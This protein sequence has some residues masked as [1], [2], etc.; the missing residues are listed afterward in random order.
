MLC[1]G[2]ANWLWPTAVL[3]IAC[4]PGGTATADGHSAGLDAEVVP[5]GTADASPASAETADD[6]VASDVPADA[7]TCNTPNP[8]GCYGLPAA[9][10][11]PKTA[12]GQ[13]QLCVQNS[14]ADGCIPYHCQCNTA[15]GQWKCD[16]SC[17]GGICKPACQ[18][19]APKVN[20]CKDGQ[21]AQPV[22]KDGVY[23]CPAGSYQKALAGCGPYSATPTPG[24]IAC[25]KTSQTY[26]LCPYSYGCCFGV[27][28][29]CWKAESLAKSCYAAVGCDDPQDCGGGQVCCL[30]K[31]DVY[32][33]TA[34]VPPADCQ[35]EGKFR[36]C[37]ADGDCQAGK[38]CCAKAKGGQYGVCLDPPC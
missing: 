19:L 23:S 38:V 35:A 28:T 10:A 14:S 34:C 30:G 37:K 18:V 16:S 11:C 1:S 15:T 27:V 8:Q 5:D 32:A 2:T 9:S 20:C 22:C 6:G 31:V 12:D 25:P 17:G 4:S 21:F 36:V 29:Q 26:E 13:S 33:D 7:T 24:K 3:A